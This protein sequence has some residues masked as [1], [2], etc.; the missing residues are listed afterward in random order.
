MYSIFKNLFFK[1]NLQRFFLLFIS[2]KLKFFFENLVR[3]ANSFI[4]YFKIFSNVSLYQKSEYIY[5][6]R[7]V[8]I[9]KSSW[10]I[11]FSHIFTLKYK[12]IYNTRVILPQ[13]KLSLKR[14]SQVYN[15]KKRHTCKSLSQ[16]R[17]KLLLAVL[18]YGTS[19]G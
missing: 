11:V 15:R 12:N 13:N 9:K 2:S 6:E 1:E 16:R 5:K 14:C 17:L 7:A 18:T 10:S 8:F 4:A 19:A 3:F